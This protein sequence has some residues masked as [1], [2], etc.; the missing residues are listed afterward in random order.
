VVNALQCCCD[1]KGC[2]MPGTLAR[3]DTAY[4]HEPSNWATLCLEHQQEVDAYWRERWED[5]YNGRMC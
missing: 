1:F 4:E 5:Y 2:P 3:Q